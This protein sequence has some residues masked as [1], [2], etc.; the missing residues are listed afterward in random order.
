MSIFILLMILYVMWW[1]HFSFSN[2][3]GNIQFYFC[4]KD[5]V[6]FLVIFWLSFGSWSIDRNTIFYIGHLVASEYPPKLVGHCIITKTNCFTTILDNLMTIWIDFHCWTL[7][8]INFFK[9]SFIFPNVFSQEFRRNN[10]TTC[11]SKKNSIVE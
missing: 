6:N 4:T 1:A 10:P 9:Y 3:N 8:T 2:Q 11:S 7:I 5:I